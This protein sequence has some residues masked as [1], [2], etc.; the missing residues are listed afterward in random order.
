MNSQM[1]EVD[2]ELN[3]VNLMIVPSSC[4]YDVDVDVDVDININVWCHCQQLTKVSLPR[5]VCLLVILSSRCGRRIKASEHS[6]HS[7]L[8]NTEL[9][10]L[11]NLLFSFI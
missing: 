5:L 4:Y 8:A 11:D 2:T 10:M 9:E 7:D 3:L 1:E 6:Q